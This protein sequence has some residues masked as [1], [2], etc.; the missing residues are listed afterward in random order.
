MSILLWIKWKVF[1]LVYTNIVR[2]VSL[3]QLVSHT[4]ILGP[5]VSW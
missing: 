4:N 5:S 1:H 2:I 3:I